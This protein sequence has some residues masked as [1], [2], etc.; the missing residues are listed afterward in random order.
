MEETL[1]SRMCKRTTNRNGKK[2]Q[3]EGERGSKSESQTTPFQCS[4]AQ[5][6]FLSFTLHSTLHLFAWQA[7]KN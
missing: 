5:E 6:E 1:S 4:S 2:T 3:R 7:G